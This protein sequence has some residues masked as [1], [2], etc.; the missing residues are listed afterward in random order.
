MVDG[1]VLRLDAVQVAMGG[2][3]GNFSR[4]KQGLTGHAALV[5]ANAADEALFDEQGLQLGMAGTFRSEISR[6]A[7]ADYD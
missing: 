5:E 4:V 6:R 7:A 3:I 2:V 1:N